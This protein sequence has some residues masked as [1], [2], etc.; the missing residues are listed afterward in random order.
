MTDD[1]VEPR[2]SKF[3]TIENTRCAN[4]DERL[5]RRSSFAGTGRNDYAKYDLSTEG[6][7]GQ[8][9]MNLTR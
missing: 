6:A 7:N 1:R 2:K 9:L 5:P 8:F 4:Y 3:A